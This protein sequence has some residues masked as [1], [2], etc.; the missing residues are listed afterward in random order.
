VASEDMM[1][2]HDREWGVPLHDDRTLFEFLILEG[3]QAGLSWLTILNKRQGYRKAY[4]NFDPATV[5]RYGEKKIKQ[6]LAD[7]SIVRNKL[8]VHASVGNAQAFLEVQQQFGSFDAY[9]WQFVDGNVAHNPRGCEGSIPARTQES[10]AMSKDLKKRGFKFVGSTIC[11]AFMQAV[12]MV[13]DH[14]VDCFRY[15]ELAG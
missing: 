15:R 3:A 10:D 5:A 2:Y 7:P 1:A 13:N 8:K 9:V 4:N 6:L 14:V 11:Y 12:G